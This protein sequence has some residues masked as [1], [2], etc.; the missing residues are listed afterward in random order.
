MRER[1]RRHWTIA[2]GKAAGPDASEP[3]DLSTARR[4]TAGGSDNRGFATGPPAQGDGCMAPAP[5]ARLGPLATTGVGSLPFTRAV[6]AAEHAAGAYELP[7]CPQLPRLYGDMVTETLG[8]D[9]GRCGWAPD[10]DRQLPAAWDAFVL[11]LARRPPGHRVVKLQ[12]TGPVTLALALERRSGAAAAPG[13]A[14]EIAIWLAASASAQVRAL[15][16]ELGLDVVLIVDEPGL[17]GAGLAPGATVAAWDPLRAAAPAW[18][19]HVCCAVPWPVLDAAAPDVVSFDLAGH[20]LPAAGRAV[21]ARAVARGGRVMWGALDTCAPDDPVAAAARIAAASAAVAS[22]ARRPVGEILRAGLVSASCG[23]GGL[24]VEDER[25]I[26]QAVGATARL[27]RGEPVGRR[28]QVVT[29]HKTATR[30]RRSR[31]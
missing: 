1:P 26:A 12:V 22:S 5:L 16:D 31:R 9:P 6:Q 7:F 25:E 3:E 11:A 21:L 4:D 13:L 30:T 15:R 27:A 19:V 17:E 29:G 18:G 28:C 8:A 2:S 14:G 23:T 24:D 10:R 20:G